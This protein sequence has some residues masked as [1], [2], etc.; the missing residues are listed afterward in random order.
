MV[1]LDPIFGLRVRVLINS[2]GPDKLLIPRGRA[3]FHFPSH[4]P[5]SFPLLAEKWS[6]G[7]PLPWLHFSQGVG[8]QSASEQ[9]V[10][11]STL[12]QSPSCAP[13][14]LSPCHPLGKPSGKMVMPPLGFL[15]GGKTISEG[16]GKGCA[17]EESLPCST[18]S[19]VQSISPPPPFQSLCLA[20]H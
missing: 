16:G 5:Q 17:S 9:S 14:H 8:G 1:H 18:H 13:S 2:P 15:I 10:P 7:T 6:T 12:R 3:T 19:E 4:I 11:C 20:T